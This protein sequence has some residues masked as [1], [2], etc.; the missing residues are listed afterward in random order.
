[1]YRYASACLLGVT[2]LGM[3]TAT[4]PA[5]PSPSAH[6]D[7]ICPTDNPTECYSRIFQPTEDFQ[8]VREGQDL[9]PGLHVRLNVWT[10]G[11]EARLNI[12]MDADNEMDGLPTEQSVV[13]VDKPEHG[14]VYDD[15]PALRDQVPQKPPAYDAAGKIL[16][17][18]E[19]DGS[20]GDSESFWNAIRVISGSSTS[21]EDV[22]LALT[23]LS[24]LAHDIYYGVELA[25][26][27]D[28][29]WNLIGLMS[30]ESHIHRRQAA[31]ILAGSLQNN[32]TALKEARKAWESRIYLNTGQNYKDKKACEEENLLSQLHQ[33][34]RQETDTAATRAKISALAGLSKDPKMRDCFVV[35]LGMGDLLKIFLKKGNEWDSTRVKIAQFVMDTFLD[36]DMG[37]ELGI[38]PRYLADLDENCREPS[39]AAN[40]GCWEYHLEK[41]MQE[42]GQGNGVEDWLS[43]FMR[44]LRMRM[45]ALPVPRRPNVDRE[46]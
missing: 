6:T 28:V 7:L 14:N 44:L 26:Q 9:P 43:D 3:A 23:D 22:E 31:S 33:T 21:A 24:D 41:M 34:L 17:P 45:E 39:R 30:S 27:G 15:K 18:Q 32:P 40:Q 35:N 4:Q 13:L 25:K 42:Q 29:L 12:P 8:I 2:C 36:E 46:L 5:A 19:P 11:K 16:P 1:M 37:A 10:G 20:G 38:W